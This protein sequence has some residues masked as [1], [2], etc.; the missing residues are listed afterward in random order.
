MAAA[1]AAAGVCVV[2]RMPA[3]QEQRIERAGSVLAA[4]TAVQ[5]DAAAAE[6]IVYK[7]RLN[8]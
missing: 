3:A 5:I 8:E 2:Q 1:A 4:V 7:K 6:K